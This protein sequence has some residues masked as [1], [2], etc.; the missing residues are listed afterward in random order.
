M[1]HSIGGGGQGG[2][3]PHLKAQAEG[4]R[5]FIGGLNY[6][7]TDQ[8]L[9][10]YLS[11]RCIIVI[12]V[13]IVI[14]VIIIIVTRWPIEEVRVKRFPDGNSRGFGFATFT[15]VSA[16]EECF[17]GTPHWVDGKQ[18]EMRKVGLDGQGGREGG[19]QK[20]AFG[21]VAGPPKNRVFV[22]PPAGQQ[23]QG[24]GD[25]QAKGP[26]GL[27]DDISDDDLRSFFMHFGVVTEIRQH[28]WEDSGRKKGF[29]YIEFH[30]EEAADAACGIHKVTLL[31]LLTMMLLWR[32]CWA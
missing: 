5:L 17:H 3:A 32:R 18:V 26:Y 8:S 30:D 13:I 6:E 1:A 29:G 2:G 28:R 14:I 23:K 16:L 15:S 4:R 24:G 31:T 22:G 10:G 27:N 7:T 21:A 11:T 25:G 19:G 9:Q 12:V 20:R